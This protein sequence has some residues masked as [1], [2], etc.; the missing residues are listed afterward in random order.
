MIKLSEFLTID[1]DGVRI[2]L[3]SLCYG[4]KKEMPLKKYKSESWICPEC[5]GTAIYG[6]LTDEEKRRIEKR[7][8]DIRR[9][10]E[11]LYI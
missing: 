8:D 7:N 1:C 2:N 10:F 11:R 6:E 4:N 3:C 9:T 5:K